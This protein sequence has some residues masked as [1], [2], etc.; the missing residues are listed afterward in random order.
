[1]KR[2]DDKHQ[3]CEQDRQYSQKRIAPPLTR[4]MKALFHVLASRG[5]FCAPPKLIGFSTALSAHLL[6][7]H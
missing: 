2:G 7:T 6:A 4:A 1:M 3:Q 5:A